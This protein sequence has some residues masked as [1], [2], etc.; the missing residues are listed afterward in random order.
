MQRKLDRQAGQLSKSEQI[1][2]ELQ[3]R[4][5]DMQEALTVKDTQ[6]DLLRKRLDEADQALVALRKQIAELQL[7]RDG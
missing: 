5:S 1:A 6:L 7:E 4:E 2:R 3:S